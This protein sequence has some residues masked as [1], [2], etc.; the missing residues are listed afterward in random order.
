MKRRIQC[1]LIEWFQEGFL[2]IQSLLFLFAIFCH[3]V[4]KNINYSCGWLCCYYRGTELWQTFCH[5]YFGFNMHHGYKTMTRTTAIF[6]AIIENNPI[7]V[8]VNTCCVF[9][10]KW[11]FKQMSIKCTSYMQEGRGSLGGGKFL[12][13]HAK[14]PEAPVPAVHEKPSWALILF[15]ENCIEWNISMITFTEIYGIS[16]YGYTVCMYNYFEY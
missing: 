13:L 4:A 2:S 11:V 5:N 3:F 7:L 14:D 15:T 1:V 8:V 12:S 10:T 9:S 16:F 6:G